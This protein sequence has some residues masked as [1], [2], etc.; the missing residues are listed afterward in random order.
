LFGRDPIAFQE[1]P[2]RVPQPGAYGIRAMAG[3]LYE[4]VS[5][6]R[7][8]LMLIGGSAFSTKEACHLD[9][10]LRALYEVSEYERGLRLVLL[11]NEKR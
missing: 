2:K 6:A 11:P 8:Q 7:G 1:M 4:W 10:S 5:D 9:A 3:S